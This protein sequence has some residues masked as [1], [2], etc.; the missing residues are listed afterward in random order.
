MDNM[1]KFNNLVGL[2]F[3]KLYEG[4]P[5][6]LHITPTL[7]LESVISEDDEDGS[8]NFS[9]YFSSTVKWLEAADYIRISL[10][11]SSGSGVAFD[12]ILS[13]RGLEALRRVPSSLEGKE[14]IG[15]RLVNYS[16]SKASEAVSTLISLAITTTLQGG[17]NIS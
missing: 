17:A 6:P 7:F 1:E 12:V 13:E 15:E 8:F 4:F 5:V 3:G 14:S 10:D 16:K 11:R 9:E 2:I